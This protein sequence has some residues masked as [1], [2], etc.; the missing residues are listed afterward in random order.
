[1]ILTCP[2]CST[3]YLVPDTAIGLSGRQV[4]CAS[5]RHSWFQEAAPA[6]PFAASLPEP[7]PA[8]SPPRASASPPARD[9]PDP[10]A[11]EAPFRPRRNPARLWTAVA[12]VTAA[13]LTAAIAALLAF[14]GPSFGSAESPLTI[15]R[16][17]APVRQTTSIGVHLYTFAARITNHTGTVQRVPET[18]AELRDAQGRVVY[19]WVIP[20][21]VPRLAPG[22]SVDINAA[23]ANVPPSAKSLRLT[24]APSGA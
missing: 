20:A 9:L 3:R 8:P 19:G 12:I 7:P 13:I 6:V 14:G 22:A 15:R 4:R 10:F 1:M 24:L 23:E 11:H 2:A 21:P 5:C 18:R 17:R 16:L